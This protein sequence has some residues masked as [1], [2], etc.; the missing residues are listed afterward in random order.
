MRESRRT[1]EGEERR[2]KIEKT[3]WMTS[4]VARCLLTVLFTAV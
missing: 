4:S 3:A 1:G 2:K